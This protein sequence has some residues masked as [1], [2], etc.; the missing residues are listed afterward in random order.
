[1]TKEVFLPNIYLMSGV[2]EK[3]VYTLFGQSELLASCYSHIWLV[4]SQQLQNIFQ[5]YSSHEAEENR[6]LLSSWHAYFSPKKVLCLTYIS[7][8]IINMLAVTVFAN[9]K[10]LFLKDDMGLFGWDENLLTV[11]HSQWT[12]P[13]RPPHPHPQLQSPQ[14]GWR[15]WRSI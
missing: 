1:M 7:F 15:H 9:P 6:S 11:K 4:Y 3:Q 2:K 10:R 12:F 5:M 14:R 13:S 8:Y